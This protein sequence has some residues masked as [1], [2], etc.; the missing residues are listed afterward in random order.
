MLTGAAYSFY[1]IMNRD[2]SEALPT[3]STFANRNHF[4]A[5]LEMIVFLG[6]G[7]FFAEPSRAFRYIYLLIS[8]EIALGLFLTGSRA[9]LLSFFAGISFFVYLLG[10]KRPVKKAIAAI[11][12]LFLLLALFVS[13]AGL[14]A[15]LDR[16]MASNSLELVSDTGRMK[17]AKDSLRI[18]KDFPVFGTGLGT[19]GEIAQKYKTSGWQA[20]YGFAHNEPLQ[21]MVEM[22]LAGFLAMVLFLF[23]YCKGVLSW[24]TRRRSP[25]AVYVT[26]GILAGM[27]SVLCHSLFDFVFHTTANM[28]LFFIILALLYRVVRMKDEQNILPIEAY[29]FRLS[30]PLKAFSAVLMCL[31]FVFLA[32]TI[33][34]RYEAE[35]IFKELE[36]KDP[37]GTTGAEGFAEYKKALKEVDKAITLNPLN[38]LYYGKKAALLSEM[39]LRKGLARGHERGEFA[40]RGGTLSLAISLYK[41]AININPTRADYHLGIGRLYGVLGAKESMKEEF[42]KARSLDPRN[43]R[44]ASYIARYSAKGAS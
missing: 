2:P 30:G 39:G 3:F 16:I 14:V 6:I 44:I 38:S 33:I 20:T 32:S 4:A 42:E 17:I 1:G 7:C 12:I 23:G 34:K 35:T 40:D 15:F 13:G 8:A 43:E 18:I 29:E 24:W 9:G 37:R 22:G 31:I 27:V 28:L 5:Y 41:K 11:A 36:R 21:L 25:F 19:F 10:K 26:L